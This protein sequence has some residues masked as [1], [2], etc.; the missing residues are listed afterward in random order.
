MIWSLCDEAVSKMPS[1]ENYVEIKH[2]IED[3]TDTKMVSS[4]KFQK[5]LGRLKS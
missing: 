5:T 1:C 2:P 4:L 3:T